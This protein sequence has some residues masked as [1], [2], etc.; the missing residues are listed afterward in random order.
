[1]SQWLRRRYDVCIIA[2]LAYIPV[3][4]SAPGKLP[5]DTKLYLYLNPVRLLSDAAFTWDTRQLGGW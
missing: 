3:L 2:L 5:A 1:M 4:L